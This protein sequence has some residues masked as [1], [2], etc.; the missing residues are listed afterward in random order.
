MGFRLV[1]KSVT[2]SD[3]ERRNGHVVCVI[4]NS[5]DFAAYYVKVVEIHQYIL[6]VKCIP[7]NLVFN[8]ISLMAIFAEN[9]PSESVKVKQPPVASKN[10]TYNQP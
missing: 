7:K 9:H 4:S 6:R 2:L 8:A 3:L 1:Q 5:V 10:V